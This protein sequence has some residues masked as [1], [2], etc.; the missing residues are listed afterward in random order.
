MPRARL[1]PCC[2]RK[3]PL[4]E[5]GFCAECAVCLH[6]ERRP[7]A[8]ALGLCERCHAA[9]GVRVLY[10]RRRGWTTEWELHLRRKT[11]EVQRELRRSRRLPPRRAARP[12]DG[13]AQEP[14]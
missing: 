13:G 12:P 2:R 11:A 7:S 4:N 14:A 3:G 1:C 6:C 5:G 10:V 9:P 8:H